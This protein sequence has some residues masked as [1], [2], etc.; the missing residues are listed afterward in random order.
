LTGEPSTPQTPSLLR[1]LSWVGVGNVVR[2]ACQW[3]TLAALA[4]FCTVQMVGQYALGLAVTAPIMLLAGMQLNAIQ[5][6]DAKGEFSFGDYLS[7][8]S[9]AT[10]AAL[11]VVAVIV[12]VSQLPRQ[13]ALVVLLIGLAKAIDA[14]ADV[15]LSAWQQREEMRVVS[16][17]WMVNAVSSV[18][19]AILAVIVTRNVVWAVAGSALGSMLALAAAIVLA[20]FVPCGN[21]GATLP[22]WH[23]DKLR[24]LTVVALPLGGV[25]ALLS[26][27]VNVPRYFVQ[28]YLGESALGLFAA[29]AYPMVLGDTLM[30]SLVQSASPRMAKYHA[31]GDGHAFKTLLIR[32]TLIGVVTGLAAVAVVLIA[33]RQILTWL[34]RPEYASQTAVFVWVVAAVSLRY[35]YVFIGVAVTAMRHFLVQFYLRVGIF[36]FLIVV[37]PLLIVRFGLV[38]GAIALVIVTAVEGAV[39]V[40]VGYEYVWKWTRSTTSLSPSAAGAS[41][42]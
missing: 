35:T 22:R 32:L 31:A 6:T 10:L 16:V 3:G 11:V 24:S 18:L 19:L 14:I 34:Y 27:N 12:F 21:G 30:G 36:L 20:R 7:L 26:L 38:G 41:R 2:G 4:K 39:W 8:R 28:H 33:G 25:V 13:T 42:F 5:A 9:L 37:S 23:L 29:A 17:V 1:N 15:I 40:S